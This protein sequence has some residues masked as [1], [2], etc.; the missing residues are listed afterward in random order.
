MPN[1]NT[2]PRIRRIAAVIAAML[3]PPAGHFSI[4]RYRRGL[5]WLAL[6]TA[7]LIL[8]VLG[9][10]LVKPWM[11]WTCI[12]IA[13]LGWLASIIDV[14]RLDPGE[15]PNVTKMVSIWALVLAFG[16]GE[17]WLSRQYVVEAFRYPSGSMIPALLVG[18]HFLITKRGHAPKRG[19]IIVFRY[20]VDPTKD[21]VKRTIAVPGDTVQVCGG[22]VLINGQPLRREPLPGPCEYDDFDEERPAGDWQPRQCIAYREWNGNESYITVHAN[23]SSAVA[24]QSC[25]NLVTV[26]PEGVFV[27]GDNRDNSHDSRFWGPV[28]YDLIKGKALFVWWS[29]GPLGIRWQRINTVLHSATV[30]APRSERPI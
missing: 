18:D 11:F 13:L 17:R 15:L 29:K 12:G 19:E 24:S 5:V 23:A 2:V 21:F 30:A 28:P 4:G 25:T 10:L 16:I 8:L 26:P 3:L 14:I 7:C 9:V 1:T 22:Q 27:M 6:Q 20:P